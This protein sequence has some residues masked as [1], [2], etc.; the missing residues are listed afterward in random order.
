MCSALLYYDKTAGDDTQASLHECYLAE[1]GGDIQI[2]TRATCAHNSVR[3]CGRDIE[4]LGREQITAR[5]ARP[6]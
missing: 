4:A 1:V 2:N 5:P 3:Q 6:A